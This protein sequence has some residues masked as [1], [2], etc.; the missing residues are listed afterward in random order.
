[1]F[2][3]KKFVLKN[4][5]IKNKIFFWK[6][7]FLEIFLVAKPFCWTSISLCMHVLGRRQGPG[8]HFGNSPTQRRIVTRH[9]SR[10]EVT[11]GDCFGGAAAKSPPTPPRFVWDGRTCQEC[12]EDMSVTSGAHRVVPLETPICNPLMAQQP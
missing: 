12:P 1:M 3:W 2:C 8:L 6:K 9:V 4:F 10:V 5:L 11:P 7:L